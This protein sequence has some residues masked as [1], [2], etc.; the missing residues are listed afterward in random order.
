MPSL[1]KLH[2]YWW[3]PP[4][5]RSLQVTAGSGAHTL[6]ITW[7]WENRCCFIFCLWNK[8]WRFLKNFIFNL[9]R[10]TLGSTV[11]L[12]VQIFCAVRYVASMLFEPECACIIGEIIGK[13]GFGCGG[14]GLNSSTEH[15]IYFLSLPTKSVTNLVNVKILVQMVRFNCKNWKNFKVPFWGSA[16]NTN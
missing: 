7:W 14:C 12:I 15:G 1:F 5:Y 3:S 16:G 13:R 2:L 10:L 9:L 11:I 4:R 8:F 6:E